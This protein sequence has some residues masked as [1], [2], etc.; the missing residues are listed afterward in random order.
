MNRNKLPNNGVSE[1]PEFIDEARVI[2]WAWSGL[3]PFGFVGNE[4]HAESEA[5]YGL[6]ICQYK[7]SGLIYRFSCDR[8]WN[9]IQDS[10]YDT[11]ESAL[12]S[13][14]AQYKNVEAV[15]QTK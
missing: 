11:V 13:L 2:K 10:P 7:D 8:S 6:A 14:P 9:T 5:V 15:W 4:S 1:P 3:Q 12:S